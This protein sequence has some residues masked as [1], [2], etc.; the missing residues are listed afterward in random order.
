MGL[1][2]VYQLKILHPFA[3]LEFENYFT[4]VAFAFQEMIPAR[5][6]HPAMITAEETKWLEII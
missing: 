4:V 5:G 2:T 6:I 3:K 1:S